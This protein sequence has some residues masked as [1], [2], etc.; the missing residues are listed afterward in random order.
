MTPKPKIPPG[1]NKM[2]NTT[3]PEAKKWAIAH[4]RHLE[5]QKKQTMNT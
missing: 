2:H 3:W 5:I 4:E 1:F